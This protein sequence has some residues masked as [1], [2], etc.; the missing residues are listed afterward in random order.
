MFFGDFDVWWGVR[1][2]YVVF[3]CYWVL[4]VWYVVVYEDVVVDW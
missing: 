4:V 3:R 1:D 2:V